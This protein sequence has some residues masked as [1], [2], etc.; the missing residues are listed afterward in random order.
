[1]QIELSD[2]VKII[3][4]I[5]ALENKVAM[6]E[7]RMATMNDHSNSSSNRPAFPTEKISDKYKRLAEYLYEKWD[8]KIELSYAQIEEILEFPLPP[9]AYNLPQSFWANTETHSYAK[10]SWLAVGYKAKVVE[11]QRVVF[12]RSI[13]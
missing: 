3:N 6:L 13:Y 5:E 9:T 12:E 1:M 10:G 11:N 7:S 2:M 4:R 8:R